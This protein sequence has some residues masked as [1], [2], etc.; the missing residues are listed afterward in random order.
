MLKNNVCTRRPTD[1]VIHEDDDIVHVHCRYNHF[2]QCLS[3][4]FSSVTMSTSRPIGVCRINRWT[5]NF[6]EQTERTENYYYESLAFARHSV[7]LEFNEEVMKPERFT[8]APDH[9]G[10]NPDTMK[11]SKRYQETTLKG[12]VS[13]FS[14]FSRASDALLK[15]TGRQ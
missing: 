10:F 7:H 5:K 14:S 13:H 11:V 2:S 1:L 4:L 8:E 9:A 6:T 12:D 15:Q 3:F